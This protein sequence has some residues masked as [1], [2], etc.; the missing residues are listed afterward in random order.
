MRRRLRLALVACAGLLAL[1]FAGPALGK[2]DPKLTVT[3]SGSQVTLAATLTEE[4]DPT[5]RTLFSVKVARTSFSPSVARPG[6]PCGTSRGG[7]Q[8]VIRSD[9]NA[10]SAPVTVST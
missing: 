5:A 7:R 2:Y 10:A 3:S 4:D 1:A 6:V 9:E 8:S